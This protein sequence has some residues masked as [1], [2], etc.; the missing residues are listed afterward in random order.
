M[1]VLRTYRPRVH[2][3]D[4]YITIATNYAGCP[5]PNCPPPT[6]GGHLASTDLTCI[7]SFYSVFS[8][9][10]GLELNN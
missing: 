5:T 4:H 3:L 1:L 7:S 10:P 8:V 9:V 2:D 6:M